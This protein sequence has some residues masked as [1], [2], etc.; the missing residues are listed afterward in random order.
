MQSRRI[1]L[2]G[3]G[4]LAMVMAV[5]VYVS[6]VVE[7]PGRLIESATNPSGANALATVRSTSSDSAINTS[8]KKDS[9]SSRDCFAWSDVNVELNAWIHDGDR[10]DRNAYCVMGQRA[11]VGKF[12]GQHLELSAYLATQNVERTSLWFRAEDAREGC[13]VRQSGAHSTAG[14]SRGWI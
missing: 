5:I 14:Y 2:W 10:I 9:A 3:S 12:K 7:K 8:G 4:I 6:H 11:A 13:C 1:V